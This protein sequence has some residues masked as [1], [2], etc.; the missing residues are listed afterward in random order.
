M[1]CSIYGSML[2]WARPKGEAQGFWTSHL[3]LK[4]KR[5]VY[6]PNMYVRVAK[7]GT[8]ASL[9]H[10]IIKRLIHL[11]SKTICVW[12]AFMCFL[13]SQKF[14]CDRII[15]FKVCV[16]AYRNCSA[17]CKTVKIFTVIFKQPFLV[18]LQNFK[19]S[20]IY[21]KHFR[22]SSTYLMNT[23]V[24]HAWHG[25]SLKIGRDFRKVKTLKIHILICCKGGSCSLKTTKDRR[26]VPSAKLFVSDMRLQEQRSQSQQTVLGLIPDE[27]G[28]V[29]WT[30]WQ[31]NGTK[32]EGPK[33][34]ALARRLKKHTP[35]P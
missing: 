10:D 31:K 5:D 23:N 27:H 21:Q 26:K 19:I 11:G 14:I 18:L 8:T 17:F 9:Y 35:Q 16:F 33:L 7:R 4:A 30:L 25:Y 2:R 15:H 6:V 24:H 20:Q 12:C 28:S 32:S 22:K 34:F 3:P 29:A 1:L 13:D